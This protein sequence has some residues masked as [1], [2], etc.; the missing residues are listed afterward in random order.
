MIRALALALAVASAAV[1]PAVARR[2][3]NPVRGKDEQPFRP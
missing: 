2:L 3:S 1:A